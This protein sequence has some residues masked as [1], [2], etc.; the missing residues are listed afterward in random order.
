[1]IVANS[2]RLKQ[3]LQWVPKYEDPN[4]II[5]SALEWERRFNS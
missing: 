4:V 2:T 5:A 1:M 3:T